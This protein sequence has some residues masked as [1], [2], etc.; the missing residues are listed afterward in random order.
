MKTR[1]IWR[2]QLGETRTA[3]YTRLHAQLAATSVDSREFKITRIP[4]SGERKEMAIPT[5]D[6]TRPSG[7][8]LPRSVFQELLYSEARRVC[9]RVYIYVCVTELAQR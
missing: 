4:V 9:V 5:I 3:R 2:Q 7:Y 8:W 1:L 6:G